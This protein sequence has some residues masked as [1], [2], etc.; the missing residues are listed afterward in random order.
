MWR[1]QTFRA[2][3]SAPMIAPGAFSVKTR[4]IFFFFALGAARRR[5]GDGQIRKHMFYIL[6]KHLFYTLWVSPIDF[7]GTY[8]LFFC[9]T[10]RT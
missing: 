5:T 6:H 9:A 3:L 10:N 1:S 8:V 7:C 4:R 2:F